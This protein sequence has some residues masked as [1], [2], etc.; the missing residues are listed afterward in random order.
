MVA[1]L[2]IELGPALALD[3]TGGWDVSCREMPRGSADV[4]RVLLPLLLAAVTLSH[5]AAA[6]AAMY[7]SILKGSEALQSGLRHFDALEYEEALPLLEAALEDEGLTAAD[8]AQAGLHAAI[9][10]IA[11]GDE[12]AAQRLIDR[13]VR[14]DPEVELPPTASP[15]MAALLDHARSSMP[16]PEPEPDEGDVLLHEPPPPGERSARIHVRLGTE[17]PPP[18][19]RVVLQYRQ[20]GDAS[21]LDLDARRVDPTRFEVRLPAPSL[22]SGA[23]EYYLEGFDETGKLIAQV[24]SAATPLLY[25]LPDGLARP[26]VVEAAPFYTRWWFWTGVGAACLTAVGLAVA[27]SGGAEACAAPADHGCL[28]VEVR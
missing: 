10:K 22:D 24:G 11:L 27:L 9:I 23:V 13:V 20:R 2:R 16:P 8:R 7:G 6:D 18:V 21:W 19:D 4:L 15:Q 26:P 17:P 28:S 25:M 14:I 5:P 1:R 12:A 3:T